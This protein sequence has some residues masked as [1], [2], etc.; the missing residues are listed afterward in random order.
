MFDT[1]ATAAGPSPSRILRPGVWSLPPGMERYVVPAG[2]ALMIE[3]EPGDTITL[4]DMEGG[5]ACELV[6]TEPA[7]PSI[8]AC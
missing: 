5:Q 6:P 2:G 3:I 8:P 4:T 7:E 1:I